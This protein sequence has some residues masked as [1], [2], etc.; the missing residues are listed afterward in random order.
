M[1]GSTQVVKVAADVRKLLERSIKDD[2]EHVLN[3]YSLPVEP[4]LPILLKEVRDTAWWMH[5]T[6]DLGVIAFTMLAPL[7]ADRIDLRDPARTVQAMAATLKAIMEAVEKRD[8][9]LQRLRAELERARTE[10]KVYKQ[11]YR[12]AIA[13]L[14]EMKRMMEDLKRR[15]QETLEIALR[16]APQALTPHERAKYLSVAVPALRRVWGEALVVQ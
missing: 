12:E 16:T 9:E 10:L 14:D 11:G 13:A 8:E 6:H 1:K 15:V 5:V 7:A 2:V 3:T 4:K